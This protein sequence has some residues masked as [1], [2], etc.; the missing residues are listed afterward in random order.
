MSLDAKGREQGGKLSDDGRRP[1]VSILNQSEKT[2]MIE[3][4]A[5]FYR[6]RNTRPPSWIDALGGELW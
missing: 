1:A 4:E 5:M 6:V 3:L 2:S